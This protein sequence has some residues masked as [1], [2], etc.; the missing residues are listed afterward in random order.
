MWAE[1][2]QEAIKKGDAYF[3]A[4]LDVTQPDNQLNQTIDAYIQA[5]E[6]DPDQPAI[7]ARLSAIAIHQGDSIKA[8]KWAKETLLR[9]PRQ[10]DAHF[11][12]AVIAHQRGQYSVAL[13]LLNQALLEP[14]FIS[15]TLLL[16]WGC[17][18]SQGHP[19]AQLAYTFLYT[20]AG[21][22]RSL[23]HPQKRLLPML[24]MMGELLAVHLAEQGD[25]FAN[26]ES[27][28]LKLLR[29]FPGHVGLMT[30]LAQF[31]R[32]QGNF[33]GAI[34]WLEKALAREPAYAEALFQ[35]GELLLE[36]DQFDKAEACY[37]QLT[38]LRPTDSFPHL[39]LGNLYLQQHRV[40]EALSHFKSALLMPMSKEERAR[41]LHYLGG[42]YK[43]LNPEAANLL[44][45]MQTLLDPK[46]P[47]AA[48]RLGISFYEAND[49]PN[50]QR[51][52]EQAWA[53]HRPSAKVA[54][55]LGYLY[56]MKQDIHSAI[57]SYEAAIQADP[58]D[59][60]PL[61]NLGVIHLDVTGNI[62][63]AITLFQEALARNS[64]YALAH[65]N[66][67][68]AYDFIGQKTEAAFYFRQAQLLNHLTQEIDQEE[69][70]TRLR[71]LNNAP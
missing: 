63:Q 24:H 64:Q 22:W 18:L 33:Q 14:G 44:H 6:L 32:R 55:N 48:L 28:F 45:C 23:R 25:Q 19:I 56:W 21:L 60:V 61:N 34:H 7:L 46:D 4:H 52:F 29:R 53:Q 35:R 65:Y 37:L 3:Q 11:A 70:N 51:V 59:E 66:L 54:S 58:L 69:L 20:L 12:L 26:A 17:R 16:S 38:R 71:N 67:G 49:F 1:Q 31:Y 42:L 10:R 5:L 50:A 36:T 27:R 8:K 68:R 15:R 13:N 2:V 40:R 43:D 9:A 30:K 39:A 57:E 47:E 62:Q 41:L